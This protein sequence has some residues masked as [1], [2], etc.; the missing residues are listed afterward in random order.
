MNAFPEFLISTVTAALG[1]PPPSAITTTRTVH[2]L[3]SLRGAL[4]T[5]PGDCSTTLPQGKITK[6]P[7]GAFCARSRAALFAVCS[8]R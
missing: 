8:F 4:G 5:L 6:L 7:G 3:R 1:H 2:W